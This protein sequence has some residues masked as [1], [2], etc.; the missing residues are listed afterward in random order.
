M[1]SLLYPVKGNVLGGGIACIE[2]SLVGDEAARLPG[3]AMFCNSMSQK[4]CKETSG[5]F[6][7][8]L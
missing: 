5:G 6:H 8:G 7:G 1:Y 4:P 3:N 2:Y